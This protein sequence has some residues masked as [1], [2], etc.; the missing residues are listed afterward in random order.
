MVWTEVHT[1]YVSIKMHSIIKLLTLTHNPQ[2]AEAKCNDII[3]LD[4]NMQYVRSS[5]TSNCFLA[6]IQVKSNGSA[7]TDIYWCRVL[8]PWAS[9]C[10]K[11]QGQSLT[12]QPAF[13]HLHSHAALDQTF[14]SCFH[15]AFRCV[16]GLISYS[17]SPFLANQFFFQNIFVVTLAWLHLILQ[18]KYIVSLV[19]CKIPQSASRLAR[20]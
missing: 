13:T 7:W 9:C 12:T 16:Q 5:T 19:F 10:L 20:Q 8:H 4:E 14:L 1:P 18:L 11:C 3:I 2:F 6:W 17:L 15:A